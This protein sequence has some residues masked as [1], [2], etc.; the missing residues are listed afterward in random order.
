MYCD[1]EVKSKYR[2]TPLTCFGE[3]DSIVYPNKNHFFRHIVNNSLQRKYMLSS[4]LLPHTYNSNLG[5][6]IRQE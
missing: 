3:Y 6:W 1:C 2:I 5:P 4:S